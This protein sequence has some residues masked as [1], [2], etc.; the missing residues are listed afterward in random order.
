MKTI[1][2]LALLFASAFLAGCTQSN[3]PTSTTPIQ[4][5][6]QSQQD[7]D[8]DELLS[9]PALQESDS[10]DDLTKDLENTTIVEESF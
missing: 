3:L 4:E 7:T 2:I 8:T 1:T 10:L 5:S 6:M 9:A